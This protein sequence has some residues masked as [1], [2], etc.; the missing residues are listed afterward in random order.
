MFIYSHVLV[1]SLIN[2]DDESR[3]VS[4]RVLRKGKRRSGSETKIVEVCI[5][6]VIRDEQTMKWGWHR[7]IRG[8]YG[9]PVYERTIT[10]IE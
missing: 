1:N 8:S 6:C 9:R 2:L 7:A 5:Q 10:R 3:T 4:Q